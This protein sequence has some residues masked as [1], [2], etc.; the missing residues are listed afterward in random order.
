MHSIEYP[1]SSIICLLY[2]IIIIII[3]ILLLLL[4]LLL[5][6]NPR[7]NEGKKKIEIENVGK[8]TAP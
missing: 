1:A 2:L 5:F 7:K 6:L 4:L 8:T 3:I